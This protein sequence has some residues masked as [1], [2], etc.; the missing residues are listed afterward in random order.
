MS[1]TLQ[2][3]PQ[4]LKI[5]RTTRWVESAFFPVAASSRDF[6]SLQCSHMR[7]A[8]TNP[9]VQGIAKVT[10]GFLGG[11][12]TKLLVNGGDRSFVLFAREHS[13]LGDCEVAHEKLQ[14]LGKVLRAGSRIQW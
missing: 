10:L 12:Q 3:K 1:G 4:I 5:N 7:Q 13:I 2:P 6:A 8:H 9:V 14:D 11:V